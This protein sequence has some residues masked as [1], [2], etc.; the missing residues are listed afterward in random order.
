MGWTLSRMLVGRERERQTI[1]AL[2]AGARLGRSAVLLVTG[3]P[4]IGKTALLTDVAESLDG[5]RVLRATGSEAE[6]DLPFAALDQLMRPGAA[7]LERIPPPQAR[8]LGIALALQPGESADR[9]AVGAAVLSLLTRWCE[10]RPLAVLV[11]D[12]HLLDQPSAE[13]LSFAARRLLA[14]SVLLMLGA[15]SGERSV[16]TEAGLPELRLGGLDADATRRLATAVAGRAVGARQAAALQDATGGNPLAVRELARDSSPTRGGSPDSPMPVPGTLSE[17]FA[18]RAAGLDAAARTALLVAAAS[19]GDVAVVGGACERLGVPMSALAAAENAGLVGVAGDRVRFAHPLMRSAV[20]AAASPDARRAAHAAIVDAL[21]AGDLDR[22]AWHRC[23]ATLGADTAA[24]DEIERV[25]A[26]AGNRG[27]HAVA[28][29]AFER[30]AVLSAA[31]LDRSRRLVLAGGAAWR[32][33]DPDRSL[34]LLDRIGPLATA[35]AD[36]ARVPAVRGMIAARN[37]DL[38]SAR[39]ALTA[40]AVAFEPLDRDEA[41][42]LHAESLLASYHLADAGGASASADAI[43]ALLALGVGGWADAVGSISIGMATVLSGGHGSER[44]RAGVDVLV[45]GAA[46]HGRMPATW[47]TFGAL[48]LRE[49]ETGRQLLEDAVEDHRA[50]ADLGEL[51][52]ILW[53]RAVDN[54]G[55]DAWARAAV[56][57][58]EA[59][60]L[61]R[62][63]GQTTVLT[64]G[65]A[66]LARVEGRSG[67]EESCRA[68]AAE[69]LALSAQRNIRMARAWSD[70]A[71]GDLE[72]AVGRAEAAVAAY[73]RI[74]EWLAAAGILDPDLS[75]GPD[76]VE[77]LLRVGRGDEAGLLAVDYDRRAQRKGQPW[78]RARAARALGLVCDDGDLDRL[79]GAAL[80]LHATTPDRFEEARSRL[81]YGSRLRRARRRV[82][83]RPHLQAALDAFEHL[84]AR[85]WAAL[86]ADE[87]TATGSIARRRDT[88]DAELLTPR[89]LQIALLLADGRTTREAAAA[90]FLSPKTVEYHLRHVYTKLGIDS[91][92]GLADR[93]RDLP[94]G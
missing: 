9:F 11:D 91:R 4:G 52:S 28:A 54:A 94:S 80:E 66:G 75:P 29:T 62:E 49:A 90:L 22:R 61:A 24:A 51:P 45:A 42:R 17:R 87:L 6:R 41:V 39:A 1:D 10:D 37:G 14:D 26:R 70:L 30:A 92:R 48:W 3:D 40:A 21:P 56:D 83:A 20:Y 31:E 47:R 88:G 34:G 13:A 7:D 12:A 78:A 76:R 38:E 65:L 89:E 57:Y 86:A 81:A 43:A 73:A 35:P 68:H 32:A 19:D 58:S 25:G 15:R 64:M 71:L 63:F 55:T 18:A 23:D 84:G 33:G 69:A 60:S 27:A 8:A 59:I 50:L 67:R 36:A 2:I 79:F 53:Y 93:L 46:E 77:A 74:D 16:L 85:S 5:M 72:L 44:I 82:G